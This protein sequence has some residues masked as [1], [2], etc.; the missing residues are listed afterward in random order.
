MTI[1]LHLVLSVI[2]EAVK[3]E[4][5]IKALTDKAA[6]EKAT[7]LAFHEDAGDESFHQRK[8]MRTLFHAVE[9]LKSNI[10][11]Y[12]APVAAQ[13]A[14]NIVSEIDSATDAITLTLNVNDRFNQSLTDSLA[15][16]C[17]KYI[18]DQMLF[19]WWGTINQNQ[20]KFYQQLIALDLQNIQRCFTKTAPALPTTPYT[21][22]ISTLNGGN[23]RMLVGETDT[24]TYVIDD[25]ALD[26][27]Q[28]TSDS[29][30]IVSITPAQAPRSFT[31][32]AQNTGVAYVTLY[33]R[34]DEDVSHTVT[35]VVVNPES[36]I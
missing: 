32:T 10:A 9:Q 3:A 7:A 30:R 29:P 22:H 12:V 5:H 31:L 24:L 8:I 35:V 20:A 33:S 16:L 26:D 18:E 4:T 13:S 23:V 11:D 17:S 1:H 2:V 19:L 34:H 15:R 6:D 21:Q 36:Q 27:V 28:G 14:D 25:D